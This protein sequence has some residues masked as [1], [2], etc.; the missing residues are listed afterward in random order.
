MGGAGLGARPFRPKQRAGRGPVY[1]AGPCKQRALCPRFTQPRVRG[2]VGFRVPG[3]CLGKV[4]GGG[5]LLG[6][7]SL[8]FEASGPGLF[9]PGLQASSAHKPAHTHALMK[10]CADEVPASSAHKPAHTHTR[11]YAPAAARGTPAAYMQLY[12]G[13]RRQPHEG[14]E[15]ERESPYTSLSVCTNTTIVSAYAYYPCLQWIVHN[16]CVCIRTYSRVSVHLLCTPKGLNPCRRFQQPLP[17]IRLP[18]VPIPA[19]RLPAV[20]LQGAPPPTQP[21]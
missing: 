7:I 6:F 5:G 19:V 9:G 21:V 14:G 8:G 1:T 20:R 2:L 12:M 13:C 15:R 16:D 10:L 11:L 4:G 3:L 18:A 17:A